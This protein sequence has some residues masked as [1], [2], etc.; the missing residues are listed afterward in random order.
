MKIKSVYPII[1]FF[2]IVNVMHSEPLWNISFYDLEDSDFKNPNRFKI[3]KGNYQT[4]KVKIKSIDSQNNNNTNYNAIL[5]LNHEEL[6]MFPSELNINTEN[7]IYTID[8]GISCGTKLNGSI[9][10]EFELE[11]DDIKDKIEINECRADI[12]SEKKSIVFSILNK[13]ELRNNFLSKIYIKQEYKNFEN[14]KIK[15][16]TESMCKFQNYLENIDNITINNYNGQLRIYY[17]TIKPN[18]EKLDGLIS[19]SINCDI[20]ASII[21]ED[22]MK[23]FEIQNKGKV[24]YQKNNL[25]SENKENFFHNS[26]VSSYIDKNNESNSLSLFFFKEVYYFVSYC[27][28]QDLDSVQLSNDE[29][30]NQNLNYKNQ[31][32]K[33]SFTMNEFNN[34]I[35]V[36]EIIFKNLDININYKIKCIF[37]FFDNK[38]DIELTYGEGMQIPMKINLNST[39]SILGKNCY[40]QNKNLDTRYCDIVNHRLIFNQFYDLNLK[41]ILKDFNLKSFNVYT[42]KNTIEKIEYMKDIINNNKSLLYSETELISLLSDYLFLIDCQENKTCQDEKDILFKKVLI[43][44]NEINITNINLKERGLVLN[45]ILLFN[46]IIENTDSINYDNFDYIINEIL[47]KRNYFFSNSTM[48][49]NQYLAN[50]FLLLFDKF[51]SIVNIFKSIYSDKFEIDEKINIYKS[52]LLIKFYTLFIRWI[53]SGMINREDRLIS[54][55]KNLI[56]NYVETPVNSNIKKIIDSETVTITG[57]DTE[58]SKNLYRNIYSAGAIS[59]KNFPLFPLKNKKQEDTEKLEDPE[60][61]SLFL[62]TEIRENFVNADISY[63]QAFKITFKKKSINNY[64]YLWNND[65]VKNKNELINNFAFTEYLDKDDNDK[66]NISCVSRIMISP[67]TIILGQTDINGSLFKEGISICSF[68][69]IILISLCLIIISLPFILSKYYMKQTQNEDKTVNELN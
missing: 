66:Y 15:F 40:K 5:K 6:K 48:I 35:V 46:N 17:S 27:A 65:Y 50:Y 53:S 62:F 37:D 30:L 4:I 58:E 21:S 32:I 34:K 64:C 13:N 9:N 61:V 22:N 56:V 41:Y 18:E 68:I 3:I 38:A 69:V 7:E 25:D 1:L 26:I 23:C 57:F 39:K 54:F 52:E 24:T 19:D 16:N 60:A 10:F 43:K 63:S 33:A 28:I 49:Y 55:C 8:V 51:I 59:Y 47:I 12:Q 67:M 44:Y 29:I 20:S 31:N 11:G 14:I 2:I 45:D 36:P 42:N